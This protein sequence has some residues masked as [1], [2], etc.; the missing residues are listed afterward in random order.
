MFHTS[1]WSGPRLLPWV[2]DWQA[3]VASQ[4]SS[5]TWNQAV[6]CLGELGEIVKKAE[7]AKIEESQRT[8]D[9]LTLQTSVESLV[10]AVRGTQPKANSARVADVGLLGAGL[11]TS[12]ELMHPNHGNRELR[13]TLQQQAHRL[14]DVLVSQSREYMVSQLPDASSAPVLSSISLQEAA[15][16]LFVVCSHT[17]AHDKQWLAPNSPMTKCAIIL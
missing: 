17:C 14:Q 6:M 11:V 8:P 13:K 10:E 1:R 16:N 3:I 4:K 7:S 5:M 15:Q 2:Q 9:R 12:S